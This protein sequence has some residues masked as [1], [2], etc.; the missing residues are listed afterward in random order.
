MCTEYCCPNMNA[1]MQKSVVIIY[2]YIYTLPSTTPSMRVTD[3][4]V[5]AAFALLLFAI[6]FEPVA[7]T[8]AD[9]LRLEPFR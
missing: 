7:E 6:V 8:D 3:D 1:F 5:G 9:D 4:D 2:I